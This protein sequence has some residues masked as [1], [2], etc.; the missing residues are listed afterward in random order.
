MLSYKIQNRS[1]G[2]KIL[3]SDGFTI[4]RFDPFTG[5]TAAVELTGPIPDNMRPAW[6]LRSWEEAALADQTPPEIAFGAFNPLEHLG[7]TR[8]SLARL[9]DAERPLWV[10]SML[11]APGSG[12]A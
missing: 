10:D 12:D 2:L 5:P 11:E 1:E 9:P 7:V 4:S 3:Q 6:M 8:E